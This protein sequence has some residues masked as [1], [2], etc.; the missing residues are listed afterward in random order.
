MC[1]ELLEGIRCIKYFAWER[2]YLERVFEKRTNEIY[3]A[4][5]ESLVYGASMI[6][7]VLSPTLAFAATLIAFVFQASA[8]SAVRLAVSLLLRSS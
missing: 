2:P 5:R 6:I 4:L 7:T 1:V 8:F 3:W